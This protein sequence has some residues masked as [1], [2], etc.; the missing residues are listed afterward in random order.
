MLYM[1]GKNSQF[2]MDEVVNNPGCPPI[3]DAF[4]TH[5]DVLY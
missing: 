2:H 5:F 1:Q 4:D 3:A